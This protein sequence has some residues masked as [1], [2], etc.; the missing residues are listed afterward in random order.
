MNLMPARVAR[1]LVMFTPSE[2]VLADLVAKARLS[3]PGLAP[4]AEA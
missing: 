1:H 4:T 2:D 3:I